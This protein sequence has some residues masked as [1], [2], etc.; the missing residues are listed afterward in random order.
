MYENFYINLNND[1]SNLGYSPNEI[2][3]VHYEV[4]RTLNTLSFN[5]KNMILSVDK[6]TELFNH[7]WQYN[8]KVQY[9]K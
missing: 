2:K 6:S 4:S 9:I 7:T 1:L 3:L 5:Y 8:D